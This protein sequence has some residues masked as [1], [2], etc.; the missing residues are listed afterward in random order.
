M[1]RYQHPLWRWGRQILAQLPLSERSI[2][3]I[4]DHKTH[5]TRILRS[6]GLGRKRWRRWKFH[7]VY[8]VEVSR[9]A[10]IHAYWS[11]HLQQ[12][13]SLQSRRRALWP[14]LF[15]DRIKYTLS[16]SF[17]FSFPWK[18][19]RFSLLNRSNIHLNPTSFIVYHCCF[20][21][22]IISRRS[23]VRSVVLVTF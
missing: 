23:S 18:V 4:A 1:S 2:Y 13:F 14:C 17:S 9:F 12:V 11:H 10:P 16:L 15:R 21:G 5:L 8:A 19:T 20:A 7:Q 6:I 22:V 3:L